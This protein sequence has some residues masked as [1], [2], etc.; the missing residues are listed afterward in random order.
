MTTAQAIWT[1]RGHLLEVAQAIE[2]GE[3]RSE[4]LTPMLFDLRSELRSLVKAL[5]EGERKNE[6]LTRSKR[7]V[8]NK[9]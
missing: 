3:K 9:N 8:G 4:V 5:E 2:N 1:V 7:R 6:G